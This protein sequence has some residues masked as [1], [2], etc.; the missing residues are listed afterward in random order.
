MVKYYNKI[1]IERLKDKLNNVIFLNL[2]ADE[3]NTQK[4]YRLNGH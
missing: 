3:L 2:Y 4:K 1:K